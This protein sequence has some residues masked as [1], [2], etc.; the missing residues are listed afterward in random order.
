MP[1]ELLR[2]FLAWSEDGQE[3]EV[4]EFRSIKESRDMRSTV[5]TKSI[6]VY[7]KTSDDMVAV[8]VEEGVYRLRNGLVVREEPK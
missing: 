7:F 5:P 8:K 1:S 6:T 3:V 2:T 4:G